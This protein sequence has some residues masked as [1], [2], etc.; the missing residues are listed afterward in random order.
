VKWYGPQ[1]QYYFAEDLIPG[2]KQDVNAEP[3]LTR[4]VN[5]TSV[6]DIVKATAIQYL[7]GLPTQNA[8]KVILGALRH[9]DA[10]VRYR[11]LRSLSSFPLEQWRDLA[12]PLLADKVKA[13]RIAAADLMLT[14]PI[15]QIPMDHRNAY[16]QARRELADYV[17][18]QADFAVGNVMIGDHFYR[19]NDF[20]NAEKYYRRGLTKDS[21][22]NYARFN[23]SAM[24][25]SQGRNADALQ[26]LEQARA[27]DPKNERVYYNLALLY[28]ELKDAKNAEANFERAVSLGTSDPNIYYN[29]GLILQQTGNVAKAEKLFLKGLALDKNALNLNYA[30]AVLYMQQGQASKAMAPAMVLKKLAPSNPDYAQLFQ[31][32][33]L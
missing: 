4:L 18:Y 20:I 2:S 21:M 12:S 29:Y 8:L 25:N 17:M 5:D 14:L 27:T 11:A 7:R 1:R 30:L 31:A 22:M 13:V 15:D 26:V 19:Q 32:L 10:Q 28:A 3:H 16:A 23:L 9:P 33:R 6:P 24:L